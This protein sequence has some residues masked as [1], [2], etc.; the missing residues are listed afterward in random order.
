MD[1]SPSLSI[2]DENKDDWKLNPDLFSYVSKQ[3]GE[4]SIDAFASENNSHLERFWTKKADVF[5]KNWGKEPRLWINPPFSMINEVIQKIKE[6]GATATLITPN[7]DNAKWFKLAEQLFTS[8]RLEIETDDI[9]FFPQSTSN[10]K[11][12]GKPPFSKILAWNL[13]GAVANCEE[14][15]DE[16]TVATISFRTPTPLCDS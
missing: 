4:C 9:S 3:F 14:N 15:Y 2:T 5:S 12:V 1:H 8:P 16:L 13:D 6:D 10:E 7:W 11:G